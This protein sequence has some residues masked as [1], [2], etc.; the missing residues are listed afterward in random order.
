MYQDLRGF[1]HDFTGMMVSFTV[2]IES[3]D[4]ELVE[5]LHKEVLMEANEVMTSRE[6]SYFDLCL[7]EDKTIR[8]LIFHYLCQAQEKELNFY[9]EIRDKVPPM[10]V[11]QLALVRLLNILLTNA[12]EAAQVS[13]EKRIDLA[14]FRS[15]QGL[16]MILGNSRPSGELNI[17]K[18]FQP[19][20]STKGSGRGTGLFTVQRILKHEEAMLL[21]TEIVSQHF[22]QHLTIRSQL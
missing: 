10:E 9:L 6:Y 12:I 18:I 8:S 15:D 7:L 17:Q 20:W 2:A 19:D 22:T 16:E 11:N 4:W 21:E 5:K 3:R 1:R 13:E 14:L